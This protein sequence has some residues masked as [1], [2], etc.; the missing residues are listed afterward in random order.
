MDEQSE[1]ENVCAHARAL[2]HFERVL[3]RGPSLSIYL[4]KLMRERSLEGGS[5]LS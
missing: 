5:S 4:Y 1:N 2:A 3:E